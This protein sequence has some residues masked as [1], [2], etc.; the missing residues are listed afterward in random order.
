MAFTQQYFQPA[1]TPEI[2]FKNTTSDRKLTIDASTTT[3][4][5]EIL[6]G[7]RIQ[8]SFHLVTTIGN[9]FAN[10]PSATEVVEI[11]MKSTTGNVRGTFSDPTLS[12]ALEASTTIGNVDMSINGTSL[13][14][15]CK[16]QARTTTGDIRL[17]LRINAGVGSDLTASTRFGRVSTDLQGFIFLDSS[18]R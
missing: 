4:N 9:I 5:V 11:T 10:I 15:D 1:P 13:K 17:D 8:S 14:D 18:D 3:A 6:I 2:E 16:V 7:Q 12:K